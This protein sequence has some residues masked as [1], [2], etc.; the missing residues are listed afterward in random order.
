MP[1]LFFNTLTRRVEEFT[2]LEPGK[3]RLYT[4]GPTVYNFAHIGNFRAYV[5]EDLLQRHLEYRGLK[6]ERVMNLTDV[7]DKTIRGC[8]DC[9]LPLA[10]FTAP[11]KKAFFEDLDTLRIKRADHFP[12]ATA[13]E[14]ISHMVEMISALMEKGHAYRA[15]DAS[16]YFRIRSF[17][18][19]GKLAHFNLDELRDGVRVRNDEY[20]K[21]NVGDF[22]LWKS[23]SEADG[24]VGWESPW[25]R[26]RPGWHIECSAMATGILGPQ[27][28]IHCGG[29]DNIF[30]HHEAEIAQSE[31][32]TGKK[33]VRLWMHCRHLQVE[34]SKMAK[35]AGNFFTLRDLMERGWSGREVRYALI[36]V[37]YREPLNFTFE[38]L[39]AARS[40][41]QRLDEWSTRLSELATGDSRESPIETGDAFGEALD[42]DLN[43]SAALAVIFDRIR[44]TNRRMDE[45]LLSPGEARSLLKWIEGVNSVLGFEADAETISPQVTDLLTRRAEARASKEW[46]LSDT[47]RDEILAAG[48]TVKDTKEGQKLTPAPRGGATC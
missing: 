26:G 5:F 39:A 33:F 1:L 8:K 20:E 34:G 37:K 12:E 32:V 3:V 11:F 13:P 45:G 4:C 44:T 36:S 21:E 46:K 35:S 47:L 14:H 42:D 16:V 2:P 19:Y 15:E 17:S 22:A 48:W 40:A 41:L 25:G 28:D 24:D 38:G 43:I 27:L 18:D 7:D 9:G 30:P 31:C 6:V 29:E 23:W 10:D